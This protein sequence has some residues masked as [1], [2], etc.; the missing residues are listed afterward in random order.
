[1]STQSGG[2]TLTF[3]GE[4]VSSSVTLLFEP[5]LFIPAAKTPSP[6]GAAL[7]SSVRKHMGFAASSVFV[8]LLIF[9]LVARRSPTGEAWGS[10]KE[11][12]PYSLLIVGMWV[13]WSVLLD[14]LLKLFDSTQAPATNIVF[15]VGALASFYLLSVII[16]TVTF[17]AFGNE[18]S[19]FQWT[20]LITSFGL[21]AFYCPLIFCA[22]NGL[23]GK[24]R[25]LATLIVALGALRALTGLGATIYNPWR[26]PPSEPFTIKRICVGEFEA[27]FPWAYDIF[28]S[29]GYLDD[30]E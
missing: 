27:N 11:N 5:T 15:G 28:V 24:F 4:W 3:I 8:A 17:L 23:E 20:E 2:K 22:A 26:P 29:C 13:I 1:M 16:A 21:F 19:T 10:V 7:T 18:W 25:S 14:F 30:F 6:K 9:Q 12:L